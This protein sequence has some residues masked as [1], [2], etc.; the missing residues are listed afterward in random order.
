MKQVISALLL[1]A[2]LSVLANDATINL[3][4]SGTITAPTCKASFVG[5]N[6]KD[7][8]FGS[9]NASD[10]M[11]KKNNTIIGAAPVKDASL[12]FTDCGGGVTRLLLSFN[13]TDISTVGFSGKAPSFLDTQNNGKSGLGFALFTDKSKT[14]V[15][16]AIGF[17]SEVQTISLSN[18][19]KSG[20]TYTW[21]VYAKMVVVSDT[22]LANDASINSNSAGKDLIAN[23]FVNIS[24]E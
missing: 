15:G 20:N 16:D 4:F 2:P 24:Y 19:P 6:G 17:K 14:A 5:T 21:P 11:G 9:I 10:I 3:T 23:A 13:G 12:K 1:C 18:V 8:A 22:L 7:I